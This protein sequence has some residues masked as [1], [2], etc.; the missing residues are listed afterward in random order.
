MKRH[1]RNAFAAMGVAGSLAFVLGSVAFLYPSYYVEGV[2]LFIF[3]S[4]AFLL[5]RLWQLYS[6][7]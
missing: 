7:R 4:V 3:G 1:F 2:Y 5:E 6:D